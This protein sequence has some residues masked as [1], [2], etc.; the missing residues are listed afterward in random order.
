MRSVVLLNIVRS[1]PEETAC[2]CAV[3]NT[4]RAAPVLFWD[5]QA[6]LT[7]DSPRSSDFDSSIVPGAMTAG[8]FNLTAQRRRCHGR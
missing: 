2:V 7:H 8:A 3:V 6:P 5:K 4:L 1:M